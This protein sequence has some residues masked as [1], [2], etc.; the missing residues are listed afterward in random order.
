MLGQPLAQRVVLLQEDRELRHLAQRIGDLVAGTVVVTEERTRVLDGVVIDPPVSEGE[1]QALPPRVDLTRAE[2]DVIEAQLAA[3][4]HA[5]SFEHG[6]PGLM[7]GVGGLRHN[8]GLLGP[9]ARA[10]E[11]AWMSPPALTATTMRKSLL[12]DATYAPIGSDRFGPRTRA[13][14]EAEGL[15]AREPNVRHL[16]DI[17]RCTLVLPDHAAL[18]KAHAALVAKVQTWYLNDKVQDRLYWLNSFSVPK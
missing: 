9:D 10:T 4:G 7:N 3:Q 15:D 6:G 5:P 17:L 2:T 11:V 13:D 16:K 14:I 12:V 8:L 18:A 1:R